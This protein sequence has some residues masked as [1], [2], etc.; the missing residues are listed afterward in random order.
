[1]VSLE[2][3]ITIISSRFE[4]QDQCL[5]T[6]DIQIQ[7]LH[8]KSERINMDVTTSRNETMR[9]GRAIC[10]IQYRM[11]DIDHQ[12]LCLDDNICATLA[13]FPREPRSERLREPCF[14]NR[15]LLGS[16][17]FVFPGQKGG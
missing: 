17:P 14:I 12:V 11:R 9:V 5:D 1:H 2:E 4:I 6:I 15:T 7:D 10:G 3:L 16:T 13:A 8:T